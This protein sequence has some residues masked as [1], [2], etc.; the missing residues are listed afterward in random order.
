[1]RLH[2]LEGEASILVGWTAPETPEG[3]GAERSAVR[4][5]GVSPLIVGLPDL[6]DGIGHDVALPIANAALDT[7]VETGQAGT[8]QDGAVNL[9]N[10]IRALREADVQIGAYRLRG[11]ALMHGLDPAALPGCP[12]ARCRSGRRAPTRVALL[13]NRSGRSCVRAP[14]DRAPN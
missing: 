7:D 2:R 1:A 8:G 11:R 12:A 9:A 3:V 13:A 10:P 6:E 5:M 4:R 14:W